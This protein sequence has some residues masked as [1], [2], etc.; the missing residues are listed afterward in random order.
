MRRLTN[1]IT[2]NWYH[3]SSRGALWSIPLKCTIQTLQSANVDL[4]IVFSKGVTKNAWALGYCAKQGRG[5]DAVSFLTGCDNRRERKLP[6]ISGVGLLLRER[7]IHK[8]ATKEEVFSIPVG[9]FL[10]SDAPFLK[11]V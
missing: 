10:R 8:E 7:F 2:Q 5:N 6:I 11:R 3:D 1:D 4:S 9:Q